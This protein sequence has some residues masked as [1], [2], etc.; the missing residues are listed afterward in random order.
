MGISNGVVGLRMNLLSTEARH[1]PSRGHM[2]MLTRHGVTAPGFG[3]I[4]REGCDLE[5]VSWL[6]VQVAEKSEIGNWKTY[7]LLMIALFYRFT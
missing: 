3:T 6:V 7:V 4:C 5:H 1:L 2:G